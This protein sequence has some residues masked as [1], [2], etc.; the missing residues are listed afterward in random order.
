MY[1]ISPKKSGTI[2]I[3]GLVNEIINRPVPRDM[4]TLTALKRCSL[5]LD[6]YLWLVYRTFALGAPLMCCQRDCAQRRF[7]DLFAIAFLTSSF[8]LTACDNS[9]PINGAGNSANH[10]VVGSGNGSVTV[11]F[12][13]HLIKKIHLPRSSFRYISS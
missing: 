8:L 3:N 10:Q 5:G 1:V 6:L 13:L 4:N 12:P 2:L 11:M 7:S 9:R